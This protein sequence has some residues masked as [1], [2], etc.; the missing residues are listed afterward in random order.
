ML[1]KIEVPALLVWGDQDGV[2]TRADQDAQM[3]AIEGARLVIY[4]GAGHGVHWEQPERFA[5]DLL[6]FSQAL[7]D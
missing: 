4:P 2:V 6:I 1:N 3:A 7:V 5:S